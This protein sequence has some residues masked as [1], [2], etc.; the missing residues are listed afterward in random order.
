MSL[1]EFLKIDETLYGCINQV[2][3]NQYNSSEPKTYGILFKSIN[4]V[5][6]PF[7]HRAVVHS[8]KP[9]TD[10][11][12]YYVPGII[13]IVRCIVTGLMRHVDLS[14]Y[15]ITMDR[16]YTSIELTEWLVEKNIAIVETLMANK[17]GIPT[18]IKDMKNRKHLSYEVY[19][20]S[21]EDCLCT[22]TL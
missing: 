1:H 12:E 3:F 17:K 2:S 11:G 10:P 4:V 22:R 7:T 21:K 18:E 13:P 8:G 9:P 16:L 14:G 5:Q 19:W 20:E 15:N 6:Y